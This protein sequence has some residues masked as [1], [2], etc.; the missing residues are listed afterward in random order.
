MIIFINVG[1]ASLQGGGWLAPLALFVLPLLLQGAFWAVIES[2]LDLVSSVAGST[3]TW[4][5]LILECGLILALGALTVALWRG[6]AA[7]PFGAA[8]RTALFGTPAAAR[9]ANAGAR[10]HAGGAGAGG[11]APP[12]T[13]E[14]RTRRWEAVVSALH[15][16]PTDTVPS[17]EQLAAEPVPALR[18][19][20][21]R[22]GVSA[23]GCLERSELL[24][25]LREAGGSSGETCSICLEDYEPGDVLRVL[26]CKHRLHI[27][28]C[29]R[30]LLSSTDY[31]R[32]AACPVCNSA[33]LPADA[34]AEGGGRSGL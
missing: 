24:A 2:T 19:R 25:R 3:D 13:R 23:D 28:C 21:S 26:P 27:E 14:Q 4:F 6:I 17:A 18:A 32:P 11:P 33:L 34:A 29:D 12:L 8:L 16:L 30:W 7:T 10:Q 22:A 15:K 31:S 5:A 20:L 9:P 1:G